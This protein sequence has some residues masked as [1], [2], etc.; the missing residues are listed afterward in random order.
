MKAR[1]HSVVF[2]A[3][4]FLFVVVAAS[5]RLSA[6]QLRLRL[7]DE[8]GQTVPRAQAEVLLT[9][10]GDIHRH[11]LVVEGEFVVVSTE[12]SAVDRWWPELAGQ[13]WAEAQILIKA[14]GY[15]PIK[16]DPAPWFRIVD[17]EA[18]CVRRASVRFPRHEPFEIEIG[19]SVV[20]DFRL[21]RPQQRSI[22]AASEDGRPISGWPVEAFM[23]WS[24]ENHCGHPSGIDFLTKAFTDENGAI[25]V[26][27]GEFEYLLSFPELRDAEIVGNSEYDNFR[28]Q[29]IRR[30]E[31]PIVPIII[32]RWQPVTIGLR[33]TMDGKPIAGQHL[34]GSVRGCPC[35]ACSGPLGETDTD[36][37]VKLEL[38]RERY[39][40]LTLG[41]PEYD[42]V[43]WEV[44]PLIF[45]TSQLVEVELR[46]SPM[47]LQEL[48]KEARSFSQPRDFADPARQSDQVDSSV[49][50]IRNRH[51]NGGPAGKILEYPSQ[52]VVEPTGWPET[53]AAIP[54]EA[55]DA[56][57]L[58]SVD[59]FSTFLS[60][61]QTRIYREYSLIV[62]ET[63]GASRRAGIASGSAV[64]AIRAGG[65]LKWT[66]GP[67]LRF[68]VLGQGFPHERELYLFFL[69]W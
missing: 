51:F 63:I 4:L 47:G 59:G 7:V 55:S 33:F 12:A 69:K 31:E 52:L 67:G 57:V 48:W 16:S 56:V 37:T 1:S 54:G 5:S 53:T 68:Q 17:R 65:W 20:R 34:S 60:E 11:P 43:F 36:G 22:R 18:D 6:G 62:R 45:R 40:S 26:P 10:W 25:Q 19:E 64:T 2:L 8:K 29:V 9:V 28:H 27:D 30:L 21:R 50:L 61:D 41:G 38:H 24:N 44:D 15:A 39:Q 32:R 49:R 3:G 42:K 58:A 14:P 35:G 66:E 46:T 13:A 23:F